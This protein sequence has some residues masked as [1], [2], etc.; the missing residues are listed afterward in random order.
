MTTILLAFAAG[1]IARDWYPA[2]Y[3]IIRAGLRRARDW[4]RSRQ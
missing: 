2:E 4:W 3:G 1:A